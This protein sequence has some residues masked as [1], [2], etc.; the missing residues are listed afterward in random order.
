MSTYDEIMDLEPSLE[1]L[2]EQTNDELIPIPDWAW[3]EFDELDWI[4]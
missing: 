3:D 1:Q 4:I 2:T